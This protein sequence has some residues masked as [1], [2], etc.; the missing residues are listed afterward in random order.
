MN[1]LT[2]PFPT[3][4]VLT[5]V[6]GMAAA[7]WADD[8]TSP[9]AQ[10]TRP[11]S[12][13]RPPYQRI[14]SPEDDA[15]IRILEGEVLSL[16]D[17]GR[18]HDAPPKAREVWTE[19]AQ[20]QGEDNFQTGDARRMFRSL[21]K[22]NAL[23]KDARTDL[24]KAKQED[25][26]AVALQAR[27]LLERA[28]DHQREAIRLV[29][30]RMGEEDG[31]VALRFYQLGQT[32][33]DAGKYVDS[34]RAFRES[35][36]IRRRILEPDNPWTAE[37]CDGLAHALE[38]L[39]RFPEAED[40]TRESIAIAARAFGPQAVPT[41]NRKET[42]AEFLED[43]SK[44][45]DAE[46]LRREVLTAYSAQAN[47][48]P[49]LMAGVYKN[50]GLNLIAQARYAD[51][52][53]LL[54]RAWTMVSG[55]EEVDS[56]V[57]ECAE[58]LGIDLI[59]QGKYADAALM[60]ATTRD[61]VVASRRLGPADVASARNNL[62]MCYVAQREHFDEAI[63]EFRACISLLEREPD[64]ESSA[65]LAMYRSNLAGAFIIRAEKDTDVIGPLPA[66]TGTL[67]KSALATRVKVLR[68]NP[69]TVMSYANLALWSNIQ[70]DFADAERLAR[71][72]KAMA[73]RFYENPRHPDYIDLYKALA[74]SLIMRG[75]YRD[76]EAPLV[77]AAE[78]YE[79]T[80]TRVASGGLER[81]VFAQENSPLALLAALLARNGKAAAA[82]GRLEEL[83]ARGL[84]DAVAGR[85]LRPL[86]V[87]ER[88]RDHEMLAGL[89]RL[90]DQLDAVRAAEKKSGRAA[91]ATVAG[92]PG[93]DDPR[94]AFRTQL[95]A[96]QRD[97]AEF[98]SALDRKYGRED[99]RPFALERV[100][101]QLATDAALIAWVDV[102]SLSAKGVRPQGEHW[103]CVVRKRGEPTW[104]DLTMP[105]SNAPWRR[106]DADLA[107]RFAASLRDIRKDQGESWQTTAKRLYRQRLEPLEPLLRS[108]GGMPPVRRLV[109]LTSA[110]LA[111]V[112]VEIL[113]D[114]SAT[115]KDADVSYAPSA[116]LFAWLR[117]RSGGKASGATRTPKLLAVADPKLDPKL[118][119]DPLPASRRAVIEIASFF[120][121]PTV[122]LGPDASEA[123]LY[124]LRE[125]D[126]L[127]AYTTLHFSTHGMADE[128][129]YLRTTLYLAQDRLPDPL[130]RA[131]ENRP[132]F[133]GRLTAGEVLRT[134]ELD[135]DLVTLHACQTGLGPDIG[136][137]GFIGFSQAFLLAGARSLVVS[138]WDSLEPATPALMKRFY[139]NY[140]GVNTKFGR[141]MTKSEALREAKQW[142]RGLSLAEVDGLEKAFPLRRQGPG[143]LVVERDPQV[144]HP[145]DHP[146]IW[147]VFILQGD[148]D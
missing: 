116:T 81:A 40:L 52:E 44:L 133:E 41:I 50:L 100:Q 24:D 68:D 63:G 105:A 59:A 113:V 36:T 17:L 7:G 21:E 104:I 3:A 14:L 96:L 90:E 77:S 46:V 101:E 98:Q 66:E 22:F 118:G 47:V 124:D 107:R 140:R 1:L 27:G 112:P 60:F 57:S 74:G 37:S 51:A 26:D 82:S 136:G 19:L 147:A 131:L 89:A 102:P 132:V 134:W 142:L 15:R 71:Q 94:K 72:G 139:E 35:L 129:D 6:L 12:D 95:D 11:K 23:P 85:T 138:L 117:E 145:Y 109:V 2:G 84:F 78:C 10:A 13:G 30:L 114:Q 108:R 76:A 143:R 48:E 39:D 92:G 69:M 29:R 135:S 25:A 54:R 106:E 43:Q 125:R 83:M 31:D 42:L 45:R 75:C 148:P 110:A 122:R 5:I 65:E 18:I 146:S 141:R 80:R 123:F 49:A 119:L 53:P 91:P 79:S 137:E 33:H 88:R 56:A 70:G 93:H 73:D 38:H 20:L 127:R 87:Q 99:A 58:A 4:T 62:A 67:L 120:P 86:T 61:F 121:D 115:L 126:G 16:R 111:G 103:A 8:A 97:Y 55:F 9:P 32:Y 128:Q 130:K 144:V 64:H 34:E 28:A